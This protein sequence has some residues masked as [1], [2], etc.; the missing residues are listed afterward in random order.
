LIRDRR[1]RAKW[2]SI[3][4]TN[5]REGA[6][7]PHR[8]QRE[9]SV[10]GVM[11]RIDRARRAGRRGAAALESALVLTFILAP[12][13]V[14]TVDFCRLFYHY[15]TIANCARNG[16]LWASD[17]LAPTQSPYTSVV[18]A[19]QAD[20]VSLNPALS[21]SNI[22]STTGTDANGNPTVTV[23][24]TY[25]FN[26]IT[27]YFGFSSVQLTRSVTMRVAPALPN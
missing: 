18:Q 27:N 5:R 19:A 15:N 20:G 6:M 17:P 11:P 22:T 7:V 24:V 3:E 21:S 1:G 2:H 13:L 16:A 14:I 12:V 26:M 9:L 10:A 23:K 4:E 25:T 8:Q